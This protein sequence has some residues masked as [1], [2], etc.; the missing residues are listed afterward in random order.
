MGLSERVRV[1]SVIG[2]FLE[3]SRFFYFRNG[4]VDPLDGEFFLGSADW[5]YRN[6]HAR[7]ECIVPIKDRALREKLWELVQMH[8]KDQRQTW[9]MHLDGNYV[10]RKGSDLGIQSQMMAVT[11][12]RAAGIEE[13][14][15]E[16]TP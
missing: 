3:H 10:Q 15:S 2:R 13:E 9:D 11:K 6:L 1:M 12:T 8:L 4:S 14:S 7:V 16:G 5:M